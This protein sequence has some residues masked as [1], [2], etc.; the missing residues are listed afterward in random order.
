[1]GQAG[2]GGAGCEGAQGAAAGGGTPWGAWWGRPAPWERFRRCATGRAWILYGPPRWA[3][4]EVAL[5]F[6][7]RHPSCALAR[8]QELHE[9]TL[10]QPSS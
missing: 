8:G 10:Q 5:C 9:V 1:M 2:G 4:S 7:G 6:C 3:A